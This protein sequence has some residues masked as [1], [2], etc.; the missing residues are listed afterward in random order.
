MFSLL[1]YSLPWGYVADVKGKRSALIVS[2]TLLMF[3]TLAFGFTNIF[4]WAIITR[5]IQ[6]ASSGLFMFMFV[7]F[8]VFWFN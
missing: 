1:I 6:G 5:F 3:S 8:F 7:L 2:T 4:Y